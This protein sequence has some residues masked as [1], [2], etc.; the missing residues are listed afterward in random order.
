M[1]R[2]I[3]QSTQALTLSAAVALTLAGC[4]QPLPEPEIDTETQQTEET[5]EPVTETVTETEQSETVSAANTTQ[6]EADPNDYM[7]TDTAYAMSVAGSQCLIPG[8]AQ[9]YE[10]FN[11]TA[12]FNRDIHALV[13]PTGG[14][15]TSNANIIVYDPVLGFHTGHS[16]QAG[17]YGP[18]PELHPGQHITIGV[19]TVIR[20]SDTAYRVE[21][22]AH[23]FTI[24]NG[25]LAQGR[26][27][28]NLAETNP[29]DVD[30]ITTST[31]A[32]EGSLCGF[33]EDDGVNYAVIAAS[34]A[35]NCP[36][37]L[38][39]AE[40]Y[41]SPDRPGEL[42]GSAGFWDSPDGW[43]C[44]RGWQIPGQDDTGA[45]RRPVC[46]AEGQGSVVIA[47]TLFF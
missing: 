44:G 26:P 22:G 31:S 6:Q 28:M 11:C 36:A 27:T 17:Q 45:N 1:K 32:P 46:S 13:G 2:R 19:F 40:L 4:A 47:E 42:Q 39:T 12:M 5:L 23:W 30:T 37:A 8:D 29:A 34:P 21:R 25:E 43:H 16:E 38:E 15:G 9:E 24:D 35:T 33:L 7:L 14:P 18:A 3:A 10:Y 41:R 20:T